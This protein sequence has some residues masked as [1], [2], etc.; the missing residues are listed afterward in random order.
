MAEYRGI[1]ASEAECEPRSREKG[2]TH[3]VIRG[4]GDHDQSVR[5]ECREEQVKGIPSKQFSRDCSFL[6][7]EMKPF[8][9]ALALDSKFGGN[10]S[11]GRTN[12]W[13]AQGSDSGG[14][15]SSI[16]TEYPKVPHDAIRG[17]RRGWN[18]QHPDGGGDVGGQTPER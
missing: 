5:K 2:S 6:T 16:R 11:S 12:V 10:R 14:V 18:G 9:L 17:A 8:E 4:D 15:E 13:T 7:G 1:G 3:D